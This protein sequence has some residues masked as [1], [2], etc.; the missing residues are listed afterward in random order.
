M[1]LSLGKAQTTLNNLRNLNMLIGIA[2][3]NATSTSTT[4]EHL[5]LS[6]ISIYEKLKQNKIFNQQSSTFIV[7]HNILGNN[8]K[9]DLLG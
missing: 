1:N 7:C 3:Y 9:T 6:F 8:K 5:P 2:L 4:E